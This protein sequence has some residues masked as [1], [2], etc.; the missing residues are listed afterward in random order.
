MP[1]LTRDELPE[2]YHGVL[3]RRLTLVTWGVHQGVSLCE[4]QVMLS[5]SAFLEDRADAL[6]TSYRDA[7]IG[8]SDRL[9]GM[10]L[11]RTVVQLNYPNIGDRERYT[12]VLERLGARYFF[13]QPL[14]ALF[15]QPD[16]RP[17]DDK[18][19]RLRRVVLGYRPAAP[20]RQAVR[21]LIDGQQAWGSHQT[22]LARLIHQRR[23]ATLAAGAARC[24]TSLLVE[25]LNQ[26]GA[27]RQ[28]CEL[29]AG[30]SQGGQPVQLSVLRPLPPDSAHYVADLSRAGINCCVIP[31][32]SSF[33][34]LQ[35]QILADEPEL[36]F[37]LWHLPAYL[38]APTYRWL[39]HLRACRPARVVCYLDRANIIGGLAAVLAG[40]PEILLSGRNLNPSHFPHFYGRQDQDYR[41]FYRLLL[42]LPGVALCTNGA[43]A[44]T[45][46]AEWL[47]I[48][49]SA[50]TVV[51]NCISQAVLGPVS[52]ERLE[53]ARRLAGVEPGRPVVLGMFRLAPEKRPLDFLEVI[54]R[55]R[56]HLPSVQAVLCGAG[57]LRQSLEE[58]RQSLGLEQVLSLPGSV[59][60]VAAMLELADVLLHVSEAEGMP[61]IVLEA[62]A[63]GL[64]V[65]ATRTGGTDAALASVLRPCQAEVG[66]LEGLSRTLVQLLGDQPLR[67][68]LGSA[69]AAEIGTRFTRERL[70]ANTLAAIRSPGESALLPW[71]P[72][73]ETPCLPP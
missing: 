4:W 16:G 50:V 3:D 51:P 62:Q 41:A 38:A 66:D 49:T 46:Y 57:Q 73:D 69:A 18:L 35:E 47:G 45:S 14:T 23:R 20:D 21:A 27:E 63:R 1:L 43:T 65:V 10:D 37:L 26:G 40:V 6:G 59:A 30:L 7:V 36:A 64:P 28:L 5:G 44:S 72:S 8:A 53:A 2:V 11:S 17:D 58:R 13:P 56:H 9:Q 31:P 67:Q 61:N 70:A 54:A 55:L 60:D 15:D 33:A 22:R 19:A 68:Q 34:G 32:P 42:Q 24:G 48:P 12:E 71:L 29:A 25:I 39:C 52:A